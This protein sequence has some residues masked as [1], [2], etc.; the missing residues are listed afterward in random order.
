[1]LDAAQAVDGGAG[2]LFIVKNYSGDRMNFQMASDMLDQEN[3]VIIVNDGVAGTVIIE[4]I[5][6]AAAERGDNLA[7]LLAL[8]NAGQQGHRLHVRGPD[9]LHRAGR[10][11]AHVSDWL[12]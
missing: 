6:G 9:F 2:V 10:G 1:M 4:K 3:A 12:A 8:G 11:Q 7:Q 5:L